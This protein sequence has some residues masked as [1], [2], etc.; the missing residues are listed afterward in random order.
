VNSAL[1]RFARRLFA[2]PP[3]AH[4]PTCRCYDDHLLRLGPL[5]VCLGCACFGV[6]AG[7]GLLATEALI[8]LGALPLLLLGVGLYLPTLAQPF[9]QVKTFKVASRLLLG[10]AIPLLL[11]GG[12][13]LPPLDAV[14]AGLRA[15]FLVV[16]VLV[17]RL[18]L[19]LRARF[20]PRPCDAC[21]HGRYPLCEGNAGRV[22]RLLEELRAASPEAAQ[23]AAAL[24]AAK[25]VAGLKEAAR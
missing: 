11:F 12:F 25:D 8:P 5:T 7:A 19:W 10:A 13:V 6:G 2:Y 3:F 15:G 22:E 1:R 4:H 23:R 14:G 17:F 18:S 24:V 9:V 21:P 20:T 16:F